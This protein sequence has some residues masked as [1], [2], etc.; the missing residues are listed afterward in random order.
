MGLFDGTMLERPVLCERCGKDIKTCDCPPPEEPDVAPEKQRLKV[1]LEKRKN[2]KLVTCIR[3]FSCRSST[4][5]SIL[6]ELKNSCGAGGSC[7]EGEIEIQGDHCNRVRQLLK[8]QG[9]K[10]S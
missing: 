9:F 6:K 4:L 8:N 10:V 2:Q 3:G 7:S 5:Q 1:L